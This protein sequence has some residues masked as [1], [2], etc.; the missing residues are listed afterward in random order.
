V[1]IRRTRPA[2]PIVG[3]VLRSEVGQQRR[4]GH[5]CVSDGLMVQPIPWCTRSVTADK[6]PGRLGYPRSNLP[7]WEAREVWTSR[8]RDRSHHYV[9]GFVEK[10]TVSALQYKDAER[11]ERVIL[12][13]RSGHSPRRVAPANTGGIRASAGD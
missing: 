8:S 9:L 6:P 13:A 3:R 5:R 10:W 7:R 4:V 2:V 1:P 11:A 12:V